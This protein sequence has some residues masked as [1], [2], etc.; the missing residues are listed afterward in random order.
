MAQPAGFLSQDIRTDMGIPVFWTRAN[1]EPPWNLKVWLDQFFM[2]V[3]VQENVNPEIILED[4]KPVI[5]E[6]EPRPETP[7]TLLRQ[8]FEIIE[9]D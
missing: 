8:Q 3:T 4:P 6:P 2:A 7:R 1:S 9:I 5:E